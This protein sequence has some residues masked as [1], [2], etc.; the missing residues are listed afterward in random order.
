[1]T[2]VNIT[3]WHPERVAGLVE[4]IRGDHPSVEIAAVLRHHDT[5]REGQLSLSLSHDEPTDLVARRCETCQTVTVSQV[6]PLAALKTLGPPGETQE[7]PKR[8]HD[9]R[10]GNRTPPPLMR[11]ADKRGRE[12]SRSASHHAPDRWVARQ[13]SEARAF[14]IRRGARLGKRAG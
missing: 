11:H 14:R 3:G 10:N 8:T 12:G 5:A 9:R 13:K 1:M 7:E 4:A 2:S 6:L